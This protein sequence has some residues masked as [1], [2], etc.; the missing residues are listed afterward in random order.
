ME[1]SCAVF[2]RAASPEKIKTTAAIMV[3]N[4]LRERTFDS[5]QLS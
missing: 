1:T 4:L 3:A 2:L 5:R